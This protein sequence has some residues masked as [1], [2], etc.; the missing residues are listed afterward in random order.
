MKKTAAGLVV[1]LQMQVFAGGEPVKAAAVTASDFE[2]K[3]HGGFGDFLPGNTVDGNLA[4]A[5]SWRAEIKDPDKG[6]WIQYDLGAEKPLDNVQIAFLSGSKR[7]YR[8][9]IEGS[10][11]GEKWTELFSGAS[12]GQTAELETFDAGGASARYVRL[13]GFGNTNVNPAEEN[14]FPKWFNIVETKI[15]V[16]E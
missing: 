2:S 5:S 3:A 15:S 7:I 10:T 11:D 4:A 14:R 16:R 6:Q 12:G 8:F 13:T 1:L 9:K